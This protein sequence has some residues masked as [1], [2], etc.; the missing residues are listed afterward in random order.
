MDSP[1]IRQLRTEWQ[2]LGTVPASRTA[3][4]RLAACEPVVARLEV[5]DLGGLVTALSPS[6]ARMSRNEAANVIT[7]M[8]NS[9]GVDELV[10]RAIVQALIP[11]VLALSRRIDTAGGPWCDLD[12]F[13]A[14]A[15]SCL[16]EQITT[17]SGTMRPYAAG[18]L[19]SGVR[20]RLRTLQASERRHSQ[21]RVDAPETLDL[22]PAGSDRTGA[23]LLAASLIEATGHGMAVAD[24]AVLYATRV[25]GMPL[26]EAAE[27]V[28][29]SVARLR[30]Q[31]RLA[32]AQLV[33]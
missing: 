30:Q 13:F 16:W 18:D 24:A 32:M 33:A 5:D 3:F 1:T 23:E 4:H 31:R 15:I 21:R 12:A 25:L 20:T 27:V 17:W 6:A 10:P 7:T 28:G 11:G 2:A 8:L 22:V 26:I 14:D 19:L 9:A 29:L